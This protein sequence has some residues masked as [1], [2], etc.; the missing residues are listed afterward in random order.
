MNEQYKQQEPWQST[1]QA[2]TL[3]H[4]G[5]STG[6]LFS[7]C[8]KYRYVLWRVWDDSKPK[9]MFIGLNPSTANEESDDPTIRRVKTFAK[10]WGFGGVYMLNLF[11]YVTDYPEELKKCDDPLGPAD[12]YL[13][14]Y[15]Q[16]S[17]KII[18]AWGNFK[19]CKARAKEVRFLLAA[20]NTYMLIENKDGSP[21]HPLYVPGNVVPVRV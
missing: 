15:A 11:T 2:C 7:S 8:G 20:C 6:A 19:E 12:Y 10:T 21:R 16:K 13:M 9:V 3:P 4:V 14:E 1:E 5:S 17:E 18:F